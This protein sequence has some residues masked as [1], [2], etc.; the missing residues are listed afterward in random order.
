MTGLESQLLVKV[1]SVLTFVDY[2][3]QIEPML[4]VKTSEQQKYLKYVKQ[5]VMGLT[6]RKEVSRD[7]LVREL[8]SHKPHGGAKKIKWV[9]HSLTL[10]HLRKV[11]GDIRKMPGKC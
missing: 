6:P 2:T 3:S 9:P 11:R 5:K 8:S 7:S 1:A 4:I 10:E